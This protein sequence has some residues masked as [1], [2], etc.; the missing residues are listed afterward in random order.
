MK[1]F[2]T[3]CLP[4][5]ILSWLVATI[6]AHSAVYVFDDVAALETPIRLMVLTKG[7]LFPVGGKLVDMYLNDC[8]LG[9]I[10]SGGDG[11]GF[12][13]YV[14]RS[15]GVHQVRAVSEGSEHTGMLL[16][17][18]QQRKVLCVEIEAG[19]SRFV[20]DAGGKTDMADAL[21]ELD[22]QYTILYLSRFVG[23]INA[24]HVLHKAGCPRGVTLRWQGTETFQDLKGKGLRIN[25][26]LASAEIVSQAAGYVDNRFS[27]EEAEDLTVV[28]NWQDFVDRLTGKTD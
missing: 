9:R 25:A 26:L 4:V 21:N 27:F 1:W 20:L 8:H 12:L 15:V 19:L 5:L 3:T 13:K 10:M 22:R 18:G 14:P 2:K 17:V 28:Q 7:R 23:T 16:V 6:P 24:R 11:Y